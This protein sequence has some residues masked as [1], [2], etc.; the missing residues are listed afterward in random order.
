MFRKKNDSLK[1]PI[2]VLVKLL[3]SE[4]N[5][6]P[7]SGEKFDFQIKK[8]QKIIQTLSIRNEKKIEVRLSCNISIE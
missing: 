7:L 5:A 3:N 8:S 6:Y 4:A 1:L 2:V